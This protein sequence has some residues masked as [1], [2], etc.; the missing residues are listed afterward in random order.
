MMRALHV[1]EHS[2][3]ALLLSHW[4]ERRASVPPSLHLDAK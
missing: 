1:V 2:A 4:S 3:F